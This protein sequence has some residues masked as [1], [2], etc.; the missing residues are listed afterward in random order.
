MNVV[1]VNIFYRNLIRKKNVKMGIIDTVKTIKLAQ[2]NNVVMIIIGAFVYTYGKDAYI[3]SYVFQYKIKQVENNIYVCSFPKSKLKNIM[4]KLENKKINYVVLDRR[5]SYRVDEKSENNNLNTY[6]E[7][8]EKAI[9]YVK[10]KRKLDNIYDSLNS[11]IENDEID[12]LLIKIKDIID[13][14]RKV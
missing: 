5:N 14:G 13:E 9:K 10:R 12:N 2:V 7:Y 8:L 3:I 4:A 6:G 11:N 1:N